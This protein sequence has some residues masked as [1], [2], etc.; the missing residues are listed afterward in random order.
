[1]KWFLTALIIFLAAAS[2]PAGA[3]AAPSAGA[4]SNDKRQTSPAKAG[5]SNTEQE[6]DTIMADDDAAMD[7]IDK[8][9]RD[10][11]GFAAHGAGEPSAELNQRIRTQLAAIQKEYEGF[12]GRHPNSADGH[13]AY[14]SFLENSGNEYA[15]GKQYQ[16]AT[17]LDPKN[18]AA[19]NDLGNFC[20][21]NGPL[22]NAFADYDRAIALNPTESVYY[23]NLATIV[24]L[25]R[26]DAKAYYHITEQQDFDKSLALYR[27]AVELDP[28]NFDLATDY[29]E[30]YYGITPLRT[31]DAL[32]AWTNALR[33]AVNDFEREGVNIHLAR[34]KILAGRFAEARAEMDA[35]TNA[36]YAALKHRLEL[37]LDEGEKAVNAARETSKGKVGEKKP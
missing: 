26:K 21:E 31:N 4:S 6:L 10:N 24:Y 25:F 34:I 19:W 14:G 2:A 36:A 22:T 9:I 30:T 17:R 12:L 7:R 29:A 18:P 27:K 28:T 11:N 23:E 37:N 13:L 5:A 16:I 3:N 15:S 1:M 35:V 8:W 33:S 32:V 20:G